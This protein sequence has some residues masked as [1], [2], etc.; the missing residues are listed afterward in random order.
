MARPLLALYPKF[1]RLDIIQR[2]KNA[3]VEGETANSQLRK[4]RKDDVKGQRSTRGGT[5]SVGAAASYLGFDVEFYEGQ[6]NQLVDDPEILRG[7]L[8][9]TSP[10]HQRSMPWHKTPSSA[11]TEKRQKILGNS[12]ASGES[13]EFEAPWRGRGTPNASGRRSS[14]LGSLKSGESPGAEDLTGQILDC[15]YLLFIKIIMLTLMRQTKSSRFKI[16][17]CHP[18]WHT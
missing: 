10:M 18:S 6:P 1:E 17:R 7:A 4:R 16:L 3:S 5:S 14:V 9:D 13:F 12:A 2:K 15:A 11:G 8:V